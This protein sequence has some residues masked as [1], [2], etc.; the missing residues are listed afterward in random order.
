RAVWDGR[1][2]VHGASIE[3]V[4]TFAFD[5]PADGVLEQGPQFVQLRSRTTGDIDGL[6]LWLDDASAGRIAMRTGVGELEVDLARLD[7]T[8]ITAELG[9]LGLHMSI[10]RY[11]EH[12]ADTAVTLRAEVPVGAGESAALMLKAVQSDGH[13][14][15]SSPVYVDGV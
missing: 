10:R 8:G 13:M 9:G 15:W 14:A 12:L 5:S 11:P 6:D 4:R 3:R 1:V 2:D 7:A